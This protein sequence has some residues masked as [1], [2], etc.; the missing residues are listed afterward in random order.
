MFETHDSSKRAHTGWLQRAGRAL[1]A[2][3]LAT[4]P[5]LAIESPSSAERPTNSTTDAPSVFG[6]ETIG[7]LPIFAPPP[8]FDLLRFLMDRE[9]NLYLEG[10]RFDLFSSIVNVEGRTVATLELVDAAT[11]TVRVTF[12]G[13]PHLVLDRSMVDAG[14]IR[15]GVNVPMEFGQGGLRAFV[16]QR[17]GA[18]QVLSHGA[19][20]LA[21]AGLGV[22]SPAAPRRGFVLDGQNGA[23][24]VLA[25]HAT[26]RYLI[27]DQTH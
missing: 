5:V 23:H 2:L 12:H 19:Q 18:E 15:V 27:L 13:R 6:D 7:T 11:D 25:V 9:A 16:G 26:R 22:T 3:A 10:N 4:A 21:L 14:A 20:E 8:L 1:T 17:V 24:T